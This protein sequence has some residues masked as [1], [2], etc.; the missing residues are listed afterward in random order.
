VKDI[1]DRIRIAILVQ[2]EIDN[3]TSYAHEIGVYSI[4]AAKELVSPML[5]A[6]AHRLGIKVF[7]WTVNV[8]ETM[9][10]LLELGVDGLITDHPDL[11]V[12]LVRSMFK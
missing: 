8:D 11:G 3:L 9:R 7:P 6:Q 4:N 2:N 1:D 10:R 12:K 5:I